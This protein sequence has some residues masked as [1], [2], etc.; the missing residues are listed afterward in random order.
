[1]N[2]S[3]LK[4]GL[5]AKEQEDIITGVY[6]S[7]VQT[8]FIHTDESPVHL[9]IPSVTKEPPMSYGDHSDTE[10]EESSSFTCSDRLKL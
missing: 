7:R 8:D 9:P 6:K 2:T 3:A 4:K 1:M 5:S 10:E